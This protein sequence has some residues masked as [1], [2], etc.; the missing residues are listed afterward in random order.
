VFHTFEYLSTPGN[1]GLLSLAA[2]HPS[3][4]IDRSLRDFRAADKRLFGNG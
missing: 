3:A 4:H 2:Q 1:A